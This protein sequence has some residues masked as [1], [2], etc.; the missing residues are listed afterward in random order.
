M[1]GQEKLEEDH[2]SDERL[3]EVAIIWINSRSLVVSSFAKV[4]GVTNDLSVR[5]LKVTPSL[6]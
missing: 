5:S 1:D 6:Y 4:Y 2:L 3:L